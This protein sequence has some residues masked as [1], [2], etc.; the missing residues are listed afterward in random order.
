MKLI[1]VSTRKDY[2]YGE[3]TK[4]FQSI[5]EEYTYDSEEE[6][7]NHRKEMEHRDFKDSGQAR[8]LVGDFHSDKP[9]EYVWFG[10]YTH[11]ADVVTLS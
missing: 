10:S 8:K 1:S 9:A 7:L 3:K 4:I 5:T 2:S 11:I 6:K